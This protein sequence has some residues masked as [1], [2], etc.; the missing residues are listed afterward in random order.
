LKAKPDAT[1]AAR[2]SPNVFPNVFLAGPVAG[3]EK[4]FRIR[5]LVPRRENH[6]KSGIKMARRER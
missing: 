2:A 1:V 3:C 4:R 5:C 6:D